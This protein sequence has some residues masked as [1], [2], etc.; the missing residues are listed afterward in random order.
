MT[1]LQK[2]SINYFLPEQKEKSLKIVR[3][4][5]QKNGSIP[6]VLD[7]DFVM[8]LCSHLLKNHCIVHCVT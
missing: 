8:C 5:S 7:V 2:K 3:T 4:L 1:H 6:N